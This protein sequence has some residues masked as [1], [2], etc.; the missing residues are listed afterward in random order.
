MGKKIWKRLGVSLLGAKREEK[1]FQ[2][3]EKA[4]EEKKADWLG[5]WLQ[6]FSVEGEF[7]LREKKGKDNW[8]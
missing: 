7:W 2:K 5:K 4:I 8:L 3:V 6:K 1:E